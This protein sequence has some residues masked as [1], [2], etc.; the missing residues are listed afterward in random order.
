M[1]CGSSGSDGNT[2]LLLLSH[3]VHGCG[4]V[5][6]V[7]HFVNT[8]RIEKNTF[9]RGCFTCIDVSHDTNISGMLK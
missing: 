1:T 2:S 4:T 3:P 8:T 6:R 7:T 5:M 9:G